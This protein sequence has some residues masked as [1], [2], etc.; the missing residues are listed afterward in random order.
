ML[1]SIIMPVYN[2]EKTIEKPS[3]IR[4]EGSKIT[5]VAL[6]KAEKD[7]DKE[8]GEYEYTDRA[9]NNEVNRLMKQYEQMNKMIK[10]FSG[11]GKKGKK[12]MKMPF[13]F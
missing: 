9:Q 8:D 12:R 2:G 6:K 13:N 7:A 11:M 3:F 1:L 10:Q 4:L 5:L